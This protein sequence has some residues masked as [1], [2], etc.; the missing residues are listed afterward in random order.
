MG[1]PDAFVNMSSINDVPQTPANLQAAAQTYWAA[2]AARYPNTPI[3]G[4]EPVDAPLFNASY[5]FST[6]QREALRAGFVAG[7]A[8]HAFARW[9]TYADQTWGSTS[10]SFGPDFL[11]PSDAGGVALGRD[12][13]AARVRAALAQ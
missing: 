11:H 2:V 4:I 8:G 9:V 1:E 10:A 6:A 12:R 3:I 13:M 7:T 5:V